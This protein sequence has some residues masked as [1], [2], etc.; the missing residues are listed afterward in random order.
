MNNIE[1]TVI[2]PCFNEEG[3]IPQICSRVNHIILKNK[4]IKFILVDNGSKDLTYKALIDNTKSIPKN[5]VLILKVIENKGYGYG[6]IQGLNKANSKFLGWTHA[7]LQTDLNDI[8]VGFKKIKNYHRD[9]LIKG[10]RIKRSFFGKILSLG[11]EIIVKLIIGEKLADINAQPKI[12]TQNIYKKIKKHAPND[13]SLDLFILLLCK[14]NN[15]PIYS[16]DVVFHKRKYGVAKGGGN[17]FSTI[18]IIVRTIKF[19]YKIKTD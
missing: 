18:K 8:L 6:I 9:F 17:F 3:N 16:F 14:K 2:I 4:N 19:I 5:N 11:M 15:I 7:D 12:F 13:F 1:L 10:R